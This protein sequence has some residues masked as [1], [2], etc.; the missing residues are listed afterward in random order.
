MQVSLHNVLLREKA[1]IRKIKTL[2]VTFFR[3]N[4]YYVK[5]KI[6]DFGGGRACRALVGDGDRR[7][8]SGT[9]SLGDCGISQ[10][11][12]GMVGLGR[13]FVTFTPYNDACVVVAD[14]WSDRSK[15]KDFVRI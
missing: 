15:K 7:G 9:G 10:V 2:I 1:F 3:V 5:E 4:K 6:A 8:V 13:E 12:Q 14:V 11:W